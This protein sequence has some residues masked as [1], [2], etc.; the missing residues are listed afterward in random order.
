MKV[1]LG[2]L[3]LHILVLIR[4]RSSDGEGIPFGSIFTLSFLLTGYVILM[5]FLTENP[6]P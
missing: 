1:L 6:E 2:I 3:I 4:A 5:M